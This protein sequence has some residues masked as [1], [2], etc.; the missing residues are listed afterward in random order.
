MPVPKNYLILIWLCI[1]FLVFPLGCVRVAPKPPIDDVGSIA[2]VCGNFTPEV[3]LD[4]PARGWIAGAGRGFAEWS[5]KIL[6]AGFRSGGGGGSCSGEGCG[7]AALVFLAL[8]VTTAT[9]GG[10]AGGVVGA[11]KAE[12]AKKVDEAENIINAAIAKLKIQETLRDHV[13]KEAQQETHKH[14]TIVE[15][16]GPASVDQT[17]AYGHLADKG[18]DMILQISVMRFGL[19]GEWV[20][21]PPLQLKMVVQ[22]K[23]IQ[24]RDDK[25]LYSDIFQ[26][27]GE[28]RKF[29]EWCADNAQALQGEFERCYSTLAKNII[30]KLFL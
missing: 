18:F 25:E 19:T 16:Y 13:L 23:V 29:S 9:I 8:I 6:S 17:L 26:Y 15:G 22:V 4:K 30:S 10:M 14:F 1:F 12:P 2:V 3:I 28:S 27:S 11:V 21:N 5:G 7:L 24:A 20:V